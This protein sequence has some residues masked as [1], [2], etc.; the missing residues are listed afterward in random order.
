MQRY[1]NLSGTSGVVAYE[2][3]RDSI[4]VRF[5]SGEIYLY[6]DAKTGRKNIAEM[7]KL[8]KSGKGLSTFIARYVH[9]AYA[10]KLS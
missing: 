8:A 4:A 5:K 7:K 6:N 3:G 9:D 1:Q 10:S 2:L